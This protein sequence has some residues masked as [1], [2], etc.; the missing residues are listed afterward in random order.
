MG[1]PGVDAHGLARW[2]SRTAREDRLLLIW[3][4]WYSP[5]GS[6]AR[7]S[8]EASAGGRATGKAWLSLLTAPSARRR[9]KSTRLRQRRWPVKNVLTFAAGIAWAALAVSSAAP[10]N[11]RAATQ[12]GLTGYASCGGNAFVES[13]SFCSIQF[14]YWQIIKFVNIS[15][16]SSGCS[17]NAGACTESAY[18][19][20]RKV[21]SLN[22]SCPDTLTWYVY[23]LG[24]CAC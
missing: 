8:T 7:A 6:A 9:E 13:N 16:N 18:G 21:A 4:C 5:P 20:G 10:A 15:C 3:P 19:A 2:P 12:Q 17:A 14:N 1:V 24:T 23:D 22:T 11:A